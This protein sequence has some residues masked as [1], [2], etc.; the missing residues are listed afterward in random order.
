MP[1]AIDQ[2]TLSVR[3]YEPNV[4]DGTRQK[5]LT[6]YTGARFTRE[7]NT[8]GNFEIT[9]PLV[10]ENRDLLEALRYDWMFEFWSEADTP[11]YM[12]GGYVTKIR[13]TIVDNQTAMQV[14]GPSYAG[15][16]AQRRLI[17]GTG[18]L[19]WAATLGGLETP[20]DPPAINEIMYHASTYDPYS[21]NP[22][23]TMREHPWFRIP[24]ASQITHVTD[25]FSTPTLTDFG[26]PRKADVEINAFLSGVETMDYLI[27]LVGETVNTD[28]SSV[29]FGMP[30][31]TWDIVRYHG[32]PVLGPGDVV[33][34]S[35]ALYLLFKV[36]GFGSNRS[37]GS[38]EV[39]RPVIL[40]VAGGGV[41]NPEYIE[42]NSEIVN[43]V[44]ALGTG[45]KASRARY[46]Y[47]DTDSIIRNGRIEGVVDAGQEGNVNVVEQ[48]AREVLNERR[49][50]KRTARFTLDAI[51]GQTYGYD[52]CF[53]DAVTVY[54]DEIGLVLNDFVTSVTCTIGGEGGNMSIQQVQAVVGNEKLARESNVLGRYLSGQ[55]RGLT[56][57]RV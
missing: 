11:E 57:L 25:D 21:L 39:A 30:R 3:V 18:S 53:D 32:D 54:W 38:S 13:W 5:D 41:S 9:I 24:N 37:V 23:G 48:K 26:I 17:G 27:G 6:V 4:R 31:V 56:N 12:F 52:F 43:F 16:L 34:P 40:D 47:E 1:R 10:A 35:D 22:A 50:P 29:W 46:E 33:W 20:G 15:W 36:P 51:P 19:A 42:D 14:S 2:P 45:N 28:T 55:K 8:V 7:R 49:Q 44:W